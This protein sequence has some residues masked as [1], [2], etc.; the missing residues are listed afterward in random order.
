MCLEEHDNFS[1]FGPAFLSGIPLTEKASV[2]LD[3]NPKS[4]AAEN[5][6]EVWIEAHGDLL[7]KFAV[8]RLNDRFLAEDLVQETFVKA[9][10]NFD[11]FRHEASVRTW[12]FQILRNEISS[13]FRKHKRSKELTQPSNDQPLIPLDQLLSPSMEN[14]EFATAVERAEFWEAMNHCF[15]QVPEH[16]LE[17]F[18]LRLSNPDEKVEELCKQLDLQP[19][20]FSVRMF[21]VRLL[22]RQCLENTWMSG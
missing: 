21:R 13:Y 5:L 11:K 16:L 15:E 6:P 7:F 3:L 22:L 8:L 18:L 19:S 17:T 4:A 1:T 9:F 2:N 20:N 14:Q 12:L 10:A